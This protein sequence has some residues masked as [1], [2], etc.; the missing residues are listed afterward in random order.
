MLPKNSSSPLLV[1]KEGRFFKQ[2]LDWRHPRCGTWLYVLTVE[3]VIVSISSTYVRVVEYGQRLW[4][5]SGT[6]IDEALLVCQ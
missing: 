1:S 3:G 6:F 4:Y 2:G 5:F